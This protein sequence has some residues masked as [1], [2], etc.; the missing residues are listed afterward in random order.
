MMIAIVIVYGYNLSILP[1]KDLAS[2]YSGEIN[3][4]MVYLNGSFIGFILASIAM[5][6]VFPSIS[7]EG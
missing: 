3:D 2:L 5:R 7:M 1:L 4:I 6:F